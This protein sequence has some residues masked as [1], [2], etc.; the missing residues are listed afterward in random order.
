MRGEATS[1][2]VLQPLIATDSNARRPLRNAASNQVDRLVL[3]TMT[4]ASPKAQIYRTPKSETIW[5][6]VEDNA[7]HLGASSAVAHA[8]DGLVA[9][10]AHKQTAIFRD[11]DSDW[12]TP[13]FALGRNEPCHEIFIFAARLTG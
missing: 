10:F 13:D 9:V 12:A 3:K 4:S 6:R 5:Q 2:L 7:F 11:G 8:P 1:N